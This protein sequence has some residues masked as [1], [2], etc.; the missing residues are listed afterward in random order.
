MEN[1]KLWQIGE[2]IFAAREMSFLSRNEPV[3]NKI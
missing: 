2:D 1:L 3:S